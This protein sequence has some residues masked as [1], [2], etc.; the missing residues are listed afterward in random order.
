M[1]P[2]RMTE[3]ERARVDAEFE[4]EYRKRQR[5]TIEEIERY[6]GAKDNGRD[7]SGSDEQTLVKEAG[8]G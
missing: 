3:E 5:E 6:F 2:H 4:R 1:A 7:Q 8:E